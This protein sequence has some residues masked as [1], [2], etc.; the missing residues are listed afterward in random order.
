MRKFQLYLMERIEGGG[1]VEF[2]AAAEKNGGDTS[3]GDGEDERRASQGAQGAGRYGG[4]STP[5][6]PQQHPLRQRPPRDCLRRPPRSLRP[7]PRS[8]PP[9]SPEILMEFW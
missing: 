3:N 5:G 6:Q 8:A 2:A 9:H 1:R 4:Q 7:P